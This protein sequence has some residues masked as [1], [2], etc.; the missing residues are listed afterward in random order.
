MRIGIMGAGWSGLATAVYLSR[1]LTGS[2]IVVREGDP[3][4]G[5]TRRAVGIDSFRCETGGSGFLTHRPDCLQGARDAGLADSLVRSAPVA[6]RRF[7]YTDRLHPLPESPP[8]FFKSNLLTWPEKLRV[9][10]ELF[11]RARRETGEESLRQFGDRRLGPAFTRVFL[12]AMAAGIHGSTPDR[13]S[14]QAAF[15]MIAQLEREH[16]GL[17]RGMIARRGG[18]A[19]GGGLV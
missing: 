4:G 9:A 8:L 19:P 7:I 15:P 11:V 10:G 18:S 1:L 16:G 12:D 13:L 3:Q 6:R 17:L 14:V 2:R 5:G